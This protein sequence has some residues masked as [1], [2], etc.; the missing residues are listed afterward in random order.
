M[1]TLEEKLHKKIRKYAFHAVKQPDSKSAD[2]A[3]ASETRTIAAQDMMQSCEGLL[4]E[5]VLDAAIKDAKE[6]KYDNEDFGDTV[7]T[8]VVDFVK[9]LFQ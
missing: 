6:G 5:S 3:S 4:T 1:A 7:A 8:K 9:G 2:F